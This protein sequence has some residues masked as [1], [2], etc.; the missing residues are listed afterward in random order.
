MAAESRETKLVVDSFVYEEPIGRKVA[1]SITFPVSG[2]LMVAVAFFEL[3]VLNQDLDCCF[4]KLEVFGLFT[5]SFEVLFELR[6]TYGDKH[7]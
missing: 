5:P 6:R 3:F 7:G 1:F 2:E 4:K